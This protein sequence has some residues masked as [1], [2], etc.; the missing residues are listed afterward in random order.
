MQTH[1]P[2]HIPMEASHRQ[3]LIDMLNEQLATT[4]D[5]QMQLKQAH[6]NIRGPWFVARHELFDNLADHMRMH[7]DALAERCGALGG[8]ARGTVRMSAE[9]SMLRAH[10]T[11]VIEGSAHLRQLIDHMATLA[12]SLRNGIVRTQKVG[13]PATED[14]ITSM[15][16]SVEQDLWFLESHQPGAMP[17]RVLSPPVRPARSQA[18]SQAAEAK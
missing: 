13:D 10:D 9:S 8:Y 6:W 17:E 1:F 15:L 11:D 12:M 5:L 2:T 14:L 4:I 7:V 3:V 16:V 18:V